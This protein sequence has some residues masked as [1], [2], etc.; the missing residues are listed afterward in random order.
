VVVTKSTKQIEHRKVGQRKRKDAFTLSIW[1]YALTVCSLIAMGCVVDYQNANL[2]G[3]TVPCEPTSVQVSDFYTNVLK[4]VLEGNCAGCHAASLP[5]P[6]GSYAFQIPEAADEAG[7]EASYCYHF[8]KW[9]D[10]TLA[11]LPL[12][13]THGGGAF[14][15]ST[16]QALVDWVRSR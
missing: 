15:E 6:S 10:N 2:P 7:Q 8:S 9:E 16:I 5:S 11:D 1:V 13:D 14:A 3:A 4:G 12:S